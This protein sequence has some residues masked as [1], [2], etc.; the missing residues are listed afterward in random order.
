MKSLIF[1]G[2]FALVT[3]SSFSSC[4]LLALPLILLNSYHDEPDVMAYHLELNFQDASGND[5]ISGI[6]LSEWGNSVAPGVSRLSAT[7]SKSC[8]NKLDNRA[9]NYMHNLDLSVC[10]IDGYSFFSTYTSLDADKCPDEKVITYSLTCLH[11]FGNA[12]EHKFVTYWEVPEIQGGIAYAKCNRIE[13]DGKVFTPII[14]GYPSRAVIILE[15]K[16]KP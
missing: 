16:E 14:D 2:L 15:G 13:F 10:K 8:E 12:R 1:S 5:L 11:V 6:K 7:F 4:E 9:I 3:M